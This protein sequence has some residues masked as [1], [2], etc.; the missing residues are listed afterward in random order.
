MRV[1]LPPQLSCRPDTATRKRKRCTVQDVRR[2]GTPNTGE[3]TTP[4]KMCE[5]AREFVL[6]SKEIR[7][8][9]YSRLL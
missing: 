5:S 8:E 1:A 7:L 2:Q 4:P 9:M 6:W 3:E